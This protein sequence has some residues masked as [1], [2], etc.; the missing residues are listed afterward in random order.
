MALCTASSPSSHSCFSGP[1]LSSRMVWKRDC[2]PS[3]SPSSTPSS[4]RPHSNSSSWLAC[5]PFTSS[6]APSSL[7]AHYL[8]SSQFTPVS[9]GTGV[10]LLVSIYLTYGFSILQDNIGRQSFRDLS[11]T[12]GEPQSLAGPGRLPCRLPPARHDLS[13]PAEHGSCSNAT[14]N[15]DPLKPCL[16]LTTDAADAAA[17]S[18]WD[19]GNLRS[20][21]LFPATSGDTRTTC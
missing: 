14:G 16:T 13:D 21:R 19:A 18:G 4:S 9:N 6:S 5:G 10:S 2:L 15:K 12:A 17:L 3:A 11:R 8:S 20:D 1:Q 7:S